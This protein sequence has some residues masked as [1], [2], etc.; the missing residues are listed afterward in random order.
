MARDTP[1][2]PG[3]REAVSDASVGREGESLSNDSWQNSQPASKQNPQ[4]GCSPVGE[5]EVEDPGSGSWSLDV[6]D[7]RTLLSDDRAVFEDDPAEKV[8]E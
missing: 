3:Y 4:A 5:A 7:E 2:I 1:S 8:E 6:K